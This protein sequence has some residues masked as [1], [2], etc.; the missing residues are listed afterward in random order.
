MSHNYSFKTLSHELLSLAL[1]MA[2][3]QLI[4]VGSGFLAMAL[5]SRLGHDVLAASALIF[6]A[7]ISIL[8]IGTS[9]LFS[10][11]IIISHAYGENNYLRIG[12]F[13]QQGWLLGLI[14]CIPITIIFLNFHSILLYFGE[15]KKITDIV[16]EFFHANAWNV[17][18]FCFAVCNQQL[19]YGVRKQRV[20]MIANI[21]GVIVLIISA[22]LLIY[23]NLGFP[24]LGVAGLGYALDL[25]GWFYFLMTF[26]VIAFLPFFKKFDLFRF[27]IHQH[28]LDV[29]HMFKIGWPICVQMGGELFSFLVMTMMV[30]W[31]GTQSLAAYQVVTQYVLL[32]LVPLFS[33][34]QACGIL[35]SQARGE[36]KYG[37]ITKVGHAAVLFTIFITIFFAFLVIV[38]PKNLAALYLDIH[39]PAN[40]ATLHLIILLFIIEI[41]MQIT[42]GIRNVLTG[43]LRGLFD[44]RFPM[45]VGLGCIWLVG[46]PSSYLLAF[47]FNTG[48]IG[49]LS[50]AVIGMFVGMIIL[51]YRWH[52]LTK[53]YP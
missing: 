27:R 12:N 1:P 30:G 51:L 49:L 16:G 28:W 31:L 36:K 35:I 11:G 24:K 50:G 44:T 14:L 32:V 34:S 52:E 3:T 8:I 41:F 46:I 7:R 26:F 40:F 42:D 37:K 2:L 15:D 4:A 6:S 38:F 18:P 5:V 53:Q 43:S 48:V 22:Y 20:D 13:T 33:L 47:H 9:I 21:G 23:G 10:L 45:Y 19:L 29:I 39:N 17:F 25:Q